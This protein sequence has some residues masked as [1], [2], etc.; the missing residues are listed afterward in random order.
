L[1]VPVDTLRAAV[2]DVGEGP[3]DVL[4]KLECGHAEIA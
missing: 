1:G 3:D 2:A 4:A